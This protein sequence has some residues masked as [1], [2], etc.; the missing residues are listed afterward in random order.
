M[1]DEETRLDAVKTTKKTFFY[2][3]TLVTVS[4]GEFSSNRLTEILRPTLLNQSCNT[5]NLRSLV[6]AGATIAYTYKSKD[7]K[8]ITTININRD[9]CK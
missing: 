4:P 8:A 3:Y 7:G 1:V 6:N 5:P 9:D 2:I